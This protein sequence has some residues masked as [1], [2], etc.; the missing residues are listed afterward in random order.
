MW[1]EAM[2]LSLPHQSSKLTPKRYGPFKIMEEISPVAYQL[3]LLI[4]WRI[5]DMFHT[6]LLS[7]YSET[8]THGPNFTQPPPD[9]I[10]RETEYEVEEIRSHQY[11]EHHKKLQY[12]VKWCRYPKVDNTWEPAENIHAPELLKIYHRRVPI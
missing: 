2:N 8:T 12:L 7:P 9:L 10:N 3:K 6:S 4:S 1:L 11:L 5:H